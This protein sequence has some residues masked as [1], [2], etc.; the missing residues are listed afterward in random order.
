MALS[1]HS[2]SYAIK[3]YAGIVTYSISNFAIFRLPRNKHL[4]DMNGSRRFGEII[5]CHH[6]LLFFFQNI[7]KEKDFF[8]APTCNVQLL[9]GTMPTSFAGMPFYFQSK[10]KAKNF[11]LLKMTVSL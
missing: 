6:N 9:K 11:F 10:A 2:I 5:I 1:G 7:F 3:S 4:C 8:K